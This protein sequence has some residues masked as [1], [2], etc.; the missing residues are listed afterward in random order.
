MK[1]LSLPLHDVGYP[2]S[3]K[4]AFAIGTVHLLGMDYNHPPTSTSTL[5]INDL[6][7]WLRTY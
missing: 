1:V 4:C 7:K 5:D 2:V 6:S 3:A